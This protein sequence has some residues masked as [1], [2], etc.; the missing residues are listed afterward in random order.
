MDNEIS[1]LMKSYEALYKETN[2][3]IFNAVCLYIKR[4]NNKFLLGGIDLTETN[5]NSEIEE[6]FIK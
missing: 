6:G 1:N 3:P 2:N 4:T 5:Q